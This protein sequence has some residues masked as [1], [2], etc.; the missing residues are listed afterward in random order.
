MKG[1]TD[2]HLLASTKNLKNKQ[3][4][5]DCRKPDSTKTA[6]DAVNSD[7]SSNSNSYSSI[8]NELTSYGIVF[9]NSCQ[10]VDDYDKIT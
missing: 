6:K 3:V 4:C 7:K 1:S 9:I 5:S 10:L 8:T 2:K